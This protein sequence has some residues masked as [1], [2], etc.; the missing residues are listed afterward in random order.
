MLK[1]EVGNKEV[2]VFRFPL[3]RSDN[4]KLRQFCGS[5][6]RQGQIFSNVHKTRLFGGLQTFPLRLEMGLL[7]DKTPLPGSAGRK[8]LVQ[9]FQGVL[10]HKNPT[11]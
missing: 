3:H 6:K 9:V 8:K 11:K 5:V 2:I 1:D 4:R 7:W 10:D